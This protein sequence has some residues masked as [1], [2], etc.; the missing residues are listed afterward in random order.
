MN[1]VTRQ[2]VVDEARSWDGTKWQHQGRLKGVACDCIGLVVGVGCAIGAL[3]F[4]LGDA[5]G[6]ALVKKYG[7]YGRMPDPAAMREFMRETLVPLRNVRDAGP[8]DIMHLRYDEEAHMVNPQH[9]AI[10][11]RTG[12]CV[13]GYMIHATRVHPK[14]V[15]EHVINDQWF[16]RSHRAYRFPA[17]Q[18]AVDEGV[19]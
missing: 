5:R 9:I 4:V 1:T 7:A 10:V 14:R 12:W 15:V 8:G 6:Q 16:R 18:R 13:G 2:Q 19:D 11:T 17:V 3:D